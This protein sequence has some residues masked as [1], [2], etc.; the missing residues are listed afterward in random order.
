MYPISP[1]ENILLVSFSFVGIGSHEIL[2]KIF[3]C[4]GLVRLAPVL[5]LNKGAL[6][7]VS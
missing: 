3:L 6:T 7:K 1:Q 4:V 2:R 5:P